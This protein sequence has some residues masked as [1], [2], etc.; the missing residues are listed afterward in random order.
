MT[1]RPNPIKGL[2]PG[3][4]RAIIKQARWR[5][6]SIY[7]FITQDLM[8]RYTELEHIRLGKIVGRFEGTNIFETPFGLFEVH[9]LKGEELNTPRGIKVFKKSKSKPESDFM[10][11]NDPLENPDTSKIEDNND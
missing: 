3:E 6:G 1:I 5:N 11:Q 7:G 2:F 10:L 4:I 8:R 9:W